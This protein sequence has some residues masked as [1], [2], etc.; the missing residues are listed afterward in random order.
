M[1]HVLALSKVNGS[2]FGVRLLLMRAADA[3]LPGWLYEFTPTI[4]GEDDPGDYHSSE[5]NFVFE[6]L[7]TCWRPFSGKHYDLARKMC[8]YWTNF[9]K[10]G[11]PNGK[12]AD[13]S[14]MPEW[15][16]F[17]KDDSKPLVFHEDGI[18]MAD[19][20]LPP[21]ISGMYSLAADLLWRKK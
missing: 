2:P 8:N 10:N 3:G 12:D 15:I 11:D 13:G 18:Q 20:A 21:S 7:A 17:T 19:E 6:N 14:P 9:A 1:N 5:L 4:P 16:P